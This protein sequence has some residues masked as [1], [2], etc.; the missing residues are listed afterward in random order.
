MNK[1]FKIT[2]GILLLVLLG[3]LLWRFSF[4]IVC[5]IIAA[6]ISFI[7]H[8]VV[9]F[10]ESLHIRKSRIPRSVCALLAL[11]IIVAGF[12]SLFAIFVP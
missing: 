2:G 7:G 10:F 12:L 4:L 9:R 6:V 3:Y 8:P 5:T 11:L 1:V